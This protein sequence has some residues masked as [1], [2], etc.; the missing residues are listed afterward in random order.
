MR[1]VIMILSALVVY[2][3]LARVNTGDVSAQAN[4]K[5]VSTVCKKLPDGTYEPNWA[6][7][8]LR[9]EQMSPAEACKF[10]RHIKIAGF[11]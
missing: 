3:A 7:L 11:T 2:S 4:M 5:I 1:L 9:M 10:L 6:G 8:C